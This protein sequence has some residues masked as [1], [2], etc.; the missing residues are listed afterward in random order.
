MLLEII[1]LMREGRWDEAHNLVQGDDSSAAAWLHALL[2]VQQG[3]L[4][5]AEYWY[6]KS[7]RDFGRRGSLSAELDALE[8]CL[9]GPET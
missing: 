6:Q 8:A 4:R 5:N 1:A 9:R 3:D 2:H 7:G